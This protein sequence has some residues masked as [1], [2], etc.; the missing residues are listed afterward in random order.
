[1][2]KRISL[3]VLAL[4]LLTGTTLRADV[5]TN[6]A[7]PEFT[8]T[9]SNGKE[10]K[11]ADYKGKY[12]I[13]EWVNYDCPFVKKHY[14]S[15]NMQ[16]LQQD[17]ASDEVVWLSINSSAEGKQ[18]FYAPEK[19]NELI[20]TA[21]AQ[22]TAYLLDSEGTVGQLY[23]AKTTPHMFIINPE[24]KLVYQGAIDDKPTFDAKDIPQSKNYVRDA[25][26]HALKGEAIDPASTTPYGCSVKY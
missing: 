19:V 16:S 15:G 6:E 20:T 7:A 2:F 4:M 5:A 9:D 12:V 14:D 17:L 1:M 11:L 25:L 8:L 10:H 21:K 22:P 18:G 3:M 13:L 24:G 23:G 26:S